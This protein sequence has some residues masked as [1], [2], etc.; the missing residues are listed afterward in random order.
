[1]VSYPI[2]QKLGQSYMNNMPGD[3]LSNKEVRQPNSNPKTSHTSENEKL[4]NEK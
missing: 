2:T 3:Y 4:L 1:M